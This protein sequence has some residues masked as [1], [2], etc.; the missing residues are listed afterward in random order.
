MND[1]VADVPMDEQLSL[2][3]ITHLAS[4]CGRHSVDAT[5]IR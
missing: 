3:A 1:D 2:L 5:N 4:G